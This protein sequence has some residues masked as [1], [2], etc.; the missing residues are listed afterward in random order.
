LTVIGLNELLA[1]HEPD[2]GG[3]VTFN[4]SASDWKGCR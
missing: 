3:T 2:I 1:L 4:V